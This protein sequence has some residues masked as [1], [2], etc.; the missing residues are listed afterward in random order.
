MAGTNLAETAHSY[1]ENSKRIK[2][3]KVGINNCKKSGIMN[4]IIQEI[5]KILVLWKN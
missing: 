4:I 1:V 3:I 2:I 5:F